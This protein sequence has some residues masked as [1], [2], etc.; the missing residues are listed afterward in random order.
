M[1]PDAAKASASSTTHLTSLMADFHSLNLFSNSCHSEDLN[2][3]TPTEV[4]EMI[5][6]V[7]V[8]WDSLA[9]RRSSLMAT[10]ALDTG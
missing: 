4:T 2:D 9:L 10:M 7:D 8:G 6:T 5:R 3:L 1:G